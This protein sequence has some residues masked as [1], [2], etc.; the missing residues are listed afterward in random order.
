MR[1]GYIKLADE[2]QFTYSELHRDFTC[3]VY[4]EKPIDM[5]FASAECLLPAGTWSNIDSF[6][7]A[8][9]D[10]LAAFVANN[11]PMILRLAQEKTRVA[12]SA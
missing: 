10:W 8:E 11:S 9:I 1:Y 12:L 4:V 6:T 5:G 7:P 2:T 3:T